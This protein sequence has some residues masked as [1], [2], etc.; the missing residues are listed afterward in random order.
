M[1]TF[2]EIPIPVVTPLGN[3]YVIYIKDNGMHEN[4]EVCVS[5]EDG[6]QWRHILTSDIKSWHN[7]TYGI[8]KSKTHER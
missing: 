4:D 6:G 5:L 3:G 7:A 2:C 1:I 8:K